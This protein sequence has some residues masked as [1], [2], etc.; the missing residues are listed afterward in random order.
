MSYVRRN[1]HIVYCATNTINNKSYIGWCIDFKERKASHIRDSRNV[2]TKFYRAIRKYGV[3]SF[4]WHILFDDLGSYEECKWIEKKMIALFDTY[5]NGYNA[6]LGGD[7]GFTGHNSGQFKKGN[8]P[9]YAGK[10]VPEHIVEKFR[11]ADR[12]KSYTPVA[13]YDINGEFIRE[14]DSIKNASIV[15]GVPAQTI[16]HICKGKYLNKS[17][18]KSQ[19]KYFF[20]DKSNISP[21]S[22]K[23]VQRKVVQFNKTGEPIFVWNNANQAAKTLGFKYYTSIHAACRTGTYSYSFKWSYL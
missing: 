15:T 2:N 22:Y 7:G 9:Y 4:E 17:A 11:K 12:S 3:E 14:F 13:Q 20:G 5:N 23:R 16:S 8:V 10:K 1:Q 6:T 19:W 18:G 21:I